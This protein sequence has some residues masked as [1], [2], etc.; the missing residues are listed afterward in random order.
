MIKR[1]VAALAAKGKP[2]H[3]EHHGCPPVELQEQSCTEGCVPP[4][5]V[6]NFRRHGDTAIGS[7]GLTM[8]TRTLGPQA[9]LAAD[10]GH[11]RRHLSVRLLEGRAD[12]GS[13][14]GH[15]RWVAQHPAAVGSKSAGKQ[16]IDFP[17]TGELPAKPVYT[18]SSSRR[19]SCVDGC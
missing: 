8:S 5:G 14:A 4:V 15:E 2:Q 9:N 17:S 11:A 19:P 10:R 7:E 1:L 12:R 16:T 18:S 6:A 13:W 3:A